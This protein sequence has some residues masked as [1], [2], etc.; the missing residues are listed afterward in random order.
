MGSRHKLP[1]NFAWAYRDG[2]MK[3]QAEIFGCNTY[4]YIRSEPAHRCIAR[5]AD[6]GFRK[7]ELMVHPGHLWPPG[8]A[9]EGLADLRRLLSARGLEVVTLNMPNIDIN[10]AAAAPAMRDYSLAMLTGIVQLAS[11]I[12]ARG[13]VIGP[14]KA[15][16]LFP[17][18]NAEL[19]PHFFAALDVL[20]PLARSGG[21]ALWVENMPFAYLPGVDAL[22]SVL[23]RYGN[24]DIGIVYD[25]ANA[26]FINEDIHAGL[27][28]CGKRLRLV[29]LSDTGRQQYRHDAIGQG[30]V[31]FR[32]IPAMLGDVDYRELPMLEIISRNADK[33]ILDSVERLA[34]LGFASATV[35]H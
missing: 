5:L 19:T 26:H 9:A 29:H 18:D 6:F 11:E 27:V 16:P 10:I 4:S 15:N 14:G 13:V 8:P 21:T 34:A 3:T 17:A 7:F 2:G 22:M 35:D 23:D 28:R 33:D 20:C 12:G 24:D 1:P 31:P 32:N 25:V 30:S